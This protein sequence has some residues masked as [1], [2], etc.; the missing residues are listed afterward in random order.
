MKATDCCVVSQRYGKMKAIHNAS[1]AAD[2]GLSVV[3][4]LKDTEK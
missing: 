3:L 2:F 4:Y 1:E